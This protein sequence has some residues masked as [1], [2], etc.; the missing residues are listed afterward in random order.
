V[1]SRNATNTTISPGRSAGSVHLLADAGREALH[2]EGVGEEVMGE[3]SRDWLRLPVVTAGSEHL[4]MGHLMRRNILTY[5]APPG[6]EGY[7][8][9]CIHPDPRHKPAPE[10]KAQIRIQVKSRY[11]TDCDRGFPVKE[12]SL[13]AFDYL[14]VAFLNIG[15]FY[16]KNDGSTGAKE[17]EFY[18]LPQ[19]F[20]RE[21]HDSSST[22]EKVKL[23]RLQDEIESFKNEKGFDMIAIDLGVPLPRK[24]R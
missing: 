20:I 22:W 10:E 17:P 7:D 23:K 1:A 5:K 21:H 16:G 2:P 3:G 18:T 11:A 6:N 4:V 13:D 9:I 12:K 14:I 8:L 15:N 24:N 19:E